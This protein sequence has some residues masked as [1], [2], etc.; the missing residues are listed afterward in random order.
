[1]NKMTDYKRRNYRKTFKGLT[2]LGMEALEKLVKSKIEKF[3]DSIDSSIGY[4]RH[5]VKVNRTAI[6]SPDYT[7]HFTL[8]TKAGLNKKFDWDMMKG[9]FKY[10]KNVYNSENTE[11]INMDLPQI[12][13]V[14]ENM[15][16]E[17]SEDEKT[18]L[19]PPKLVRQNGYMKEANENENE[20]ESVLSD[21][22]EEPE[23]DEE[24]DDI[25]EE[26]ENEEDEEDE[27]KNE[28]ENLP[29][30][31]DDFTEDDYNALDALVSKS[32]EEKKEKQQK[33]GDHNDKDDK[34]VKENKNEKSSL[35]D[36]SFILGGLSSFAYG[37]YR[38]YYL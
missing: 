9:D 4:V 37:I 36:F 3:C 7:F 27:N 5:E 22:P 24:T 17:V 32:L 16:E 38:H 15:S 28:I 33:V 20:A 19:N 1:M 6:D 25:P 34:A 29:K 10:V 21:I 11:K 31:I 8:Y 35:I 12:E 23:E 18:D 14:S 26:P 2:Q 13:E 30:N